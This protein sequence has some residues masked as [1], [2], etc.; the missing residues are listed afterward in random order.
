M[1]LFFVMLFTI[2]AAKCFAMCFI[3][4]NKQLGTYKESNRIYAGIH[5]V[6]GLVSILFIILDISYASNPLLLLTMLAIIA[7]CDCYMFWTNNERH[8][9]NNKRWD[10]FL[11]T[12]H[13]IFMVG[14]M[15]S[16]CTFSLLT[17]ANSL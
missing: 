16:L 1:E 10:A 13:F 17:L 5:I 2:T 11:G 14:F 3:Y 9:K 7:L 15:L 12:A 8:K 6:L 4:N